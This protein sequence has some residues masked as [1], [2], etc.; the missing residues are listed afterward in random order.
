MFDV[1]TFEKISLA[2]LEIISL[3]CL[4]HLWVKSDHITKNLL[5]SVVVLIPLIGPIIYGGLFK[6]PPPKGPEEDPGSGDSGVG[7]G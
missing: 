5:W 2:I 6:L 3:C 7:A 4:V 1:I